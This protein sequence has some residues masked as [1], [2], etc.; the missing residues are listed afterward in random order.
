MVTISDKNTVINQKIV[1]ATTNGPLMP[2]EYEF[3]FKISLPQGL[4]GSYFHSSGSGKSK[5]FCKVNY[6][7]TSE[8]IQNG[9]S[10]DSAILGR[11]I[12]PVF[13]MHKQRRSPNENVVRFIHNKIKTWYCCNRG[14]SKTS[15]VLQKDLANMSEKVGVSIVSDWLGSK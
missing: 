4:P 14:E 6:T 10:D 9:V 13:I 3:P 7:L 11:S 12:C 5:S 2:G 1:T 8:I 15:V